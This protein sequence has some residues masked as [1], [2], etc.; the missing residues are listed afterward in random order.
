LFTLALASPTVAGQMTI[1]PDRTPSLS[2]VGTGEVIVQP[3]MARV[4]LGVYVFDRDLRK[5]K[6]SSDGSVRRLLDV[7]SSYGVKAAE[8]SSSGL[9]IIPKYSE[10]KEPEFLGY[11]V[12]R[13]IELTLR[14]L[15]RMDGL[16]DEAIQAGANRDFSVALQSS[17]EREL[18]QKAVSL[19]V[20][21]AKAQAA[22]LAAG[23]GVS[24]G[25]V[26]S[27]SPGGRNSGS[28]SYSVSSVSFGH[29]A[30]SPGSIRLS[31]EISVA[32][33]LQP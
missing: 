28:V 21:D 14:D 26:R 11:E 8:V 6:A 16:I 23:F 1:V 18:R 29:G 31:A 13:S 15:S 22:R 33:L 27:I 9:N 17:Q 19:A 30:F 25:P 10:A 7:A 20:D 12:S 3:D 24:L 32:F 4:S 2:V 5:A